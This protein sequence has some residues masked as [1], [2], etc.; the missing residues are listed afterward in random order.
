MSKLPLIAYCNIP[1]D[2]Y[3]RN[4][5][6]SVKGQKFSR[7]GLLNREIWTGKVHGSPVIFRNAINLLRAVHK[8]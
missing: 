1:I 6:E 5:I 7:E 3:S 8:I 4:K 2:I